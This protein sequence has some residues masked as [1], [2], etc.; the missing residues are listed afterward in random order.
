MKAVLSKESPV[1]TRFEGKTGAMKANLELDMQKV[2][3]MTFALITDVSPTDLL[4]DLDRNGYV[5]DGKILPAFMDLENADGMNLGSAFAP[6]RQEIY[7]RLSRIV[8]AGQKVNPNVAKE[9]GEHLKSSVGL[10]D[11]ID[12]PLAAL[13]NSAR[14][15]QEK[16]RAVQ[17]AKI[18]K[19]SGVVAKEHKGLVQ[20][21]T[22]D[23][24][25]EHAQAKGY[26]VF[27]AG[28]ANAARE[29]ARQFA[30]MLDEKKY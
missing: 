21:A 29:A 19:K 13:Q 14:V 26:G 30:T 7:T 11:V 16:Q 18:T 24:V 15:V 20:D 1:V 4:E 17:V 27:R 5:K 10:K 23:Q 2:D 28:G 9:F 22:Y 12:D 25:L 3:G 6:H 8:E